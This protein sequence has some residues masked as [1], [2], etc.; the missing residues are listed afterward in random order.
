[1]LTTD[2]MA[3]TK[4]S[5]PPTKTT[6]P[7]CQG[8]LHVE[9]AEYVCLQCGFRDSGLPLVQGRGNYT[10]ESAGRALALAAKLGTDIAAER[11]LEARPSTITYLRMKYPSHI[12]K[13]ESR[14]PGIITRSIPPEE[15]PP[16]R[17]ATSE[18]QRPPPQAQAPPV[19][20][21]DPAHASG[22]AQTSSIHPIL[23]ALL[24]ELPARG[25]S[26]APRERAGWLRCWEAAIDLQYLVVDK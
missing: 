24:R 19:I 2:I 10:P 17:A 3:A 7:K 15:L 14:H 9:D 12:P 1:M 23:I 21:V 4:R 22:P 8:Q 6:C 20:L 18:P 26:W 5:T 16:Q 13:G 11:W 25:H